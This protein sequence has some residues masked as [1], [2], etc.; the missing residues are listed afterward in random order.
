MKILQIS[1]QISYPF[2]S[3]GRLSIYGITKSLSERGHKIVFVTYVKEYPKQEHI[4]ELKKFV[5]QFLLNGILKIVYGAY[6]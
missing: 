4:I 5:N 2:D 1:P 6:F 3:G